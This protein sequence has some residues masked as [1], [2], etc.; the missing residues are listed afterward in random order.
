MSDSIARL[1]R[2]WFQ[3]PIST[4]MATSDDSIIGQLTSNGEFDSTTAQVDAWRQQ[5]HLLKSWCEGIDGW[6]FLE[7]TI[8]RMGRRIDAVV[9]FG[10][11]VLVIEFK[12]GSSGFDGGAIEQVWDYALDLKNFHEAS[13]SAQIVPIL[14]ATEAQSSPI[15][16][17][18]F[19]GDHVARPLLLH[20][21]GM[22]P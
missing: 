4:F 5:I 12:V 11:A 10:P 7:F 13:H 8:P 19:A 18:E 22:R 21:E 9:I 20:N 16:V 2:A 1:V 3:A 6:V 15:P 17:L 14:V